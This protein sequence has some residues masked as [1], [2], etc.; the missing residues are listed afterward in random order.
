MKYLFTIFFFSISIFSFAQLPTSF[1]L[2]DYNGTNY[3]SSVKSQEG[4]TCWTHGT[5]ASIESNLIMTGAWT[6]NGETGEP[7]LAEYHLDWW[8][9]Y[10]QY[11]NDDLGGS[12]SEGLDVHMGGD[13]RVSTAYLSRL[14]GAV[15]D[16]DG[17]SYDTPPTR[18]DADFHY[19]YPRRVEWYNAEEDL[20][21]IDTIKYKL[22]QY[23]AVATCMCY[24]G[25]FIDGNYNHYQPSSSSMLPNHS[26]TIIGWDD[27]HYVT[28]AGQFGAWL[29]KNSWGAS[30][31]YSGYFWISYYDKWSCKE[32]DMGAVSF[33]DVEPLQYDVVYYHDYHGWRDT[34]QESDSAFNAFHAKEDVRLK[35]VSFFADSVNLNY[36]IKIYKSFDGFELSDL[37]STV[38][39]NLMHRG[40]YTIDLETEVI[41]NDGEDFYIFL[42]LS[43]GGQPYDRTSDVP[44]LL[45]GKTRTVG[46]IYI[47]MMIRQV[48]I[49]QVIFVLKV[50]QLIM[51][52]S[53]LKKLTKIILIFIRIRQITL[54]KLILNIKILFHLK[55]L[56]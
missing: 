13:Y 56:I 15:R 42:Y 6:A 50:W 46:K 23:G 14:E 17:Q 38:S 39:G 24:D 55:Y 52:I 21:K 45:G 36:E 8:N 25:S 51:K 16:V 54:F 49:K 30:W 22:M 19:Y 4:G 43:K 10:N 31:G 48:L 27:N 11:N 3:V 37:Q 32:P 40:F 1:D 47:I 28:A 41:I 26:V 2:R 35:S 34:K 7:N 44:V 20:S 53:E 12:N 29:V 33:I 9:G 5:M 18:Y